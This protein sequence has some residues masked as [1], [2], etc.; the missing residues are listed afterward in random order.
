MK[1]SSQFLTCSQYL[2]GTDKLQ[3]HSSFHECNNQLFIIGFDG[4]GYVLS[5]TVAYLIKYFVKL[6]GRSEMVT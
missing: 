2:I 1:L 6:V 5:P 3:K 4:D